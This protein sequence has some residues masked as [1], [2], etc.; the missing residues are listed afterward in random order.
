MS[1]ITWIKLKTDM[2][3]N[4]KIK[5]IEALPDADTLIV[6]W[7]KLLTHAGRANAGGY[8]MLTENIPMNT[9]EMATIF[10]RPLNTVRLAISTFER[11]GM[12][13]K[14]D[15]KVKISNWESHQNIEGMERAKLLNAERNR[16]FRERKKNENLLLANSGDVSVTSHDS[17]ELE[18]ELD[19]ELDIERE[20]EK[21][22]VIVADAPSLPFEEIISYLNERAKTSYRASGKKTQGLIKARLNEGFTIDDFQKV[23]DIKTSQWLTDSKMSGYLRPETLFGTKFES[24]LNEKGGTSSGASER[25]DPKDDERQSRISEANERRKRIAGIQS[26]RDN[27]DPF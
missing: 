11:Y 24:Y 10:N 23:I 9:E 5:L 22:K 15:G 14:D 17:T 26:D 19:I 7:V 4:E 3:D 1:E 13:Y 16:K 12:I 6:I 8:I 21:K 2:F 20:E 25:S 18:L 27:D